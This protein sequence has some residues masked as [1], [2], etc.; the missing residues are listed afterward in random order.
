MGIKIV[1]L[2]AANVITDTDLLP[3]SQATSTGDRD[4]NKVSTVA[5]KAYVNND[6]TKKLN[7]LETT[8]NANYI[9]PSIFNT[10]VE[11]SGDTMTGNL[12][13]NGNEIR[14]FSAIIH[15]YTDSIT[16]SAGHNGS[17]VMINRAPL[18]GETDP[19]ATVTISDSP[20]L[21]NGF[22]VMIIQIGDS[23]VKIT[24][25]GTV[26]LTQSDGSLY[27]RKKYSQINLCVLKQ[28]PYT[29][30]LSGDMV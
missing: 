20:K 28:T 21:P 5:L 22:N 6:V 8:I 24:K 7:D 2:S 12:D 27:T 9:D 15:E 16:L 14:N 17:I 13:M 1:E 3:I 4:T 25:S 30:W 23:K 10:F 29:V 18:V 11:L 19:M 26:D